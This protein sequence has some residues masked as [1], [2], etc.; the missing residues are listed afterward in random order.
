MAAV[1]PSR[2]LIILV[3]GYDDSAHR[4]D[5]LG[6][7]KDAF[8]DV[9]DATATTSSRGGATGWTVTIGVTVIE[10]YEAYWQDQFLPLNQR[11]LLVRLLGGIVL[12]LF[13]CFSPSTWRS[14]NRTRIWLTWAAVGFL[15]LFVWL[16]GTV[17]V[18]LVAI[19]NLKAGSET[20]TAFQKAIADLGIHMQQL[21]AWA[22]A[23]VILALLGIQVNA[24]PNIA[25]LVRRYM[26]NEPDD[27]AVPLQ[28][29]FSRVV[30][31]V[32]RDLA[33]NDDRILLIGHSFGVIV[34]MDALVGGMDKQ[35]NLMTLGGFLAALT[36]R[37]PR[38]VSTI[39]ACDRSATLKSWNDYYSNDDWFAGP[40]PAPALP[41]K[42]Q[43]HRVSNNIPWL[44]RFG[45]A[46][47]SSYFTNE[48]VLND[49]V[50]W[51]RA[52]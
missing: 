32:V 42:F 43:E 11:K 4:N 13:Y 48:D 41:M 25:D 1:A 47:H 27:K 40:T 8:V 30:Q 14:L 6:R 46:S 21:P 36:S 38:L 49:V 3:P 35:V 33:T 12:L 37:Y 24:L 31:H 10:M 5:A 45:M 26:T 16:Y 15:L 51:S 44:Q 17:A 20:I 34:A 19:G 2:S 29:R 50:R 52:Q 28:T 7:L 39:E 22:W 18:S 9:L 23:S